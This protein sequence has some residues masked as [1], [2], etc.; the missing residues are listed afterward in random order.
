MNDGASGRLYIDL[1]A[2]RANYRAVQA[3]VAP[4][5]C[6]AVVK[7]DGYGLGADVVAPIFAEEGCRDFFVTHQSEA[8]ALRKSLGA[9]VRIFVLNG[10]PIGSEAVFASN[11]LIPVLNSADQVKAWAGHCQTTGSRLPCALQFDTGMTRLG[12][13][14]EDAAQI[15]GRTDLRAQMDLCLLISHLACADEGD[16]P[17]NA[18]QVANF[19][20]ITALFPDVPASLSNSAA[21]LLGDQF[22]HQIVRAGIFLYGGIF[23][24]NPLMAP[25]PVVRLQARILQIRAV[26]G[27]VGVGYGLTQRT[28]RP[29]RLATLGVGYADGWPRALSGKGSA[30]AGDT[31]LPMIGRVSMDS[32]TVDIGDTADGELREGDWVDLIGPAYDIEAVAADAGTISYELLTQLGAR[33]RRVLIRGGEETSV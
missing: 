14:L 17:T 5:L 31:R 7:A 23:N 11:A 24:G 13:S 12:L 28:S 9:D 21:T 29:T 1:D 4:A 10:L 32:I 26:E 33:Y 16:N 8:I 22:H 25:R 27:G 6:G 20:A 18:L 15:A 2:L 19:R 3:Q 30:W